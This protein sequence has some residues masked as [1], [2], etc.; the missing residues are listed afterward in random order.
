VVGTVANFRPQKRLDVLVRAAALVR[1]ELADVRFVLVGQGPLEPEIRELAR[2]LGV[3]DT[4]VFAGFRDDAP[5][6]MKAFDVFVLASSYEGLSIAML[7]AM[8]LERPMVLT[9][10]GG[11]REVIVDGVHARLV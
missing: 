9:D 1:S 8:T 7:E 10:V 11:I 5:R 6:V 2:A 4:V 3:D